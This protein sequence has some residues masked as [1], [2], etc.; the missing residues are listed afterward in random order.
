VGDYYW[1]KTSLGSTLK[2]QDKF[3]TPT[4]EHPFGDVPLTLNYSDSF[5]MNGRNFVTKGKMIN[6]AV[7]EDHKNWVWFSEL[8]QPD[9]IPITN[10][11]QI[12]DR[13]GGDTTALIGLLGNLAVFSERGIFNL[14]IPSA[15]PTAWTMDEAEPNL[16]TKS[17]DSIVEYKGGAFFCT[18]SGI[19]YLSP[20]FEV[21]ELSKAISDEYKSIYSEGNAH[22]T[23]DV[24][25]NR[26]CV[27]PSKGDSIEYIL[28]LN[29]LNSPK[30]HTRGS[31]SANVLTKDEDNKI[32][33]IRQNG[34]SSI[35]YD[36]ESESYGFTQLGEQEAVFKTGWI[37][38]SELGRRE[39]LKKISLK[40]VAVGNFKIDVYSRNAQN[41]LFATVDD[42]GIFTGAN[43]YFTT[44]NATTGRVFERL[45][46][47]KYLSIQGTTYNDTVFSEISTPD[48]EITGFQIVQTQDANLGTIDNYTLI[49]K[50]EA[51]TGNNEANVNGVN[52][53]GRITSEKTPIKSFDLPVSPI[54]PSSVSLR[55][56]AR[57]EAFMIEVSQDTT[58]KGKLEIHNMELEIE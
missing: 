22:S 45:S 30:W 8:G 10:Y 34:S 55:L 6:N 29:T 51:F 19:Y 24:L 2:F 26:L 46:K 44:T 56:G 27:L 11:I 54:H 42:V 32:Y 43:S 12:K 21:T 41:E 40:Y 47:M 38:T 25:K 58:S 13:Q 17:A 57:G 50:Y 9:V 14:N 48:A 33:S 5:Y 18:N 15:D 16:G 28:D 37:S 49:F 3:I 1:E 4:T 23:I 35:I 53:V 39:N 52:L 20:N 36:M 7:E 31:S